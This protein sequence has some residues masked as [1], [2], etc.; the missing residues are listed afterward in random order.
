MR[1]L[2]NISLDTITIAGVTVARKD[3]I[4]LN[5]HA[6]NTTL[7]RTLYRNNGAYQVPTGKKLL[8]LAVKSTASEASANRL[9]FGYGDNAVLSTTP[10]TNNVG[11]TVNGVDFE[12]C[13]GSATDR[14]SS[15]YFE[16]PAGKYPYFRH[17]IASDAFPQV[18]CV[19]VDA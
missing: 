12:V 3:A 17:T 2:K 10:P 8:M 11:L 5:G 4:I 14:E 13:A 16:V 7:Y 6:G 18:L 1:V 19:L 9:I 15:M